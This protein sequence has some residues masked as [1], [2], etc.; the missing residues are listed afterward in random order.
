MKSN[1]PVK[2]M[3]L[4]NVLS[5][6][7]YYVNIIFFNFVFLFGLV[8]LF[9]VLFSIYPNKKW[10]ITCSLF[11][12]PS[13][14]FWCSGIHKDGLILSA[15]GV[16]IYCFY[17][18]LKETFAL[19]YLVFILLSFLLIFSLRNYILFALLP[20]IF[21]WIIAEKHPTHKKKIFAGIYVSGLAC[22]FIIPLIFPSI[23][24]PLYLALK[25]Q[26]FLQLTAGSQITTDPLQPTIQGFISFLPRALDMAF[27]RPHP[28]EF[29]NLSYIPAIIETILLAVLILVSVISLSKTFKVPPIVIGLFAFSVSVLLI[30]GY[31]IPFTGA[32]VRY[33]SVVLPLLITPLLC[34]TNFSFSKKKD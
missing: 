23:N 19:K 15:I 22:F 31:T 3:A 7:S 28:T 20:F 29:A 6:N 21:C 24:P 1:L 33:R 4:F 11:L 25:Q 14:L 18:L 30:C 9:K 26:E 12:L 16:C 34:I 10:V 17:K 27:L 5:N 2:M 32:I 8:A 13:T